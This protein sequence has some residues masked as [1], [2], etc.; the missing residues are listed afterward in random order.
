MNDG[1]TAGSAARNPSSEPTKQKNFAKVNEYMPDV[2]P[3]KTGAIADPVQEETARLERMNAN[4]EHDRAILAKTDPAFAKNRFL[5]VGHAEGNGEVSDREKV[6]KDTN[7]LE[8]LIDSKLKE[9]G[10]IR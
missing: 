2:S 7:R 5:D 8:R 9:H 6:K 1:F 4:Y 10:G 3:A